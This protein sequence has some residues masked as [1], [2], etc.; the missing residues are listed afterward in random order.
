MQD[1]IRPSK[2]AAT[3]ALA[4]KPSP[5]PAVKQKVTAASARPK[6]AQTKVVTP[7]AA[8][9]VVRRA[10]AKHASAHAP[11]PA[12]TLMRKSVAKPQNSLKRTVKAHGSTD[13][14]AQRNLGE[15]V[16]ATSVLSVDEQRLSR[17]RR[18]NK[19][20]AVQRF[21]K[22]NSQAATAVPV[23]ITPKAVA[24]AAQPHFNVAAPAP[25]VARPLKAAS[26]HPSKAQTTADLL[27]RALQHATSHE[28]PAHSLR[29]SDYRKT[30]SLM[31]ASGLALVVIAFLGYQSIPGLRVKVASARAGI[32]A[33]LPQY[34]PAGY[35]LGQL[36]YGQGEVMTQF[37]SNSNDDNYTLLQKHSDWDSEALRTNF[38][39]SAD[40]GYQT[41]QSGGQTI[42]IFG[43]QNA[44]W[45]SGGIWYQIVSNGSLTDQQLIHLASS[46]R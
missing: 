32:A 1:V 18:I 41:V 4:A 13:A 45:V 38:V 5:K 46:L 33:S 37:K 12:Q 16:K 20:N 31:V 14:L 26:A 36:S 21:S 2:L 25:A 44:T 34:Q 6:T 39:E 43:N 9:D 42:Y 3:A 27:E 30:I 23:H 24:P 22:T 17:A 29:P 35:S 19:S 40:P 8:Q 7:K 28:Q 11:K 10:P 15:I